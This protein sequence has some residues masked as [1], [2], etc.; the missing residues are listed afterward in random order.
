MPRRGWTDRPPNIERAT[1]GGLLAPDM[2]N[3]W[4]VNELDLVVETVEGARAAVSHQC[5]HG[6][7]QAGLRILSAVLVDV[8]HGDVDHDVIE[9][10]PVEVPVVRH[11]F[12]SWLLLY[13]PAVETNGGELNGVHVKCRELWVRA[14]RAIHDH[15]HGSLL[16]QVDGAWDEIDHDVDG[17]DPRQE[18]AESHRRTVRGQV[19]RRKQSPA[20]AIEHRDARGNLGEW[21]NWRSGRP[22]HHVR[23]RTVRG[24]GHAVRTGSN[25]RCGNHRTLRRAYL[26]RIY[27]SHS[28]GPRVRHKDPLPVGRR[29][30]AEGA[31]SHA[32]ACDERR[33]R[34]GAVD[35]SIS[36]DPRNTEDQQLVTSVIRRKEGPIWGDR[37]ASKR[38]PHGE[39]VGDQKL[40]GP[41]ADLRRVD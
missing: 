30:H 14:I 11:P 24:Y 10:I 12:A 40:L 33:G 22:A 20:Q 25:D 15:R 27:H 3:R 35:T 28:V 32:H 21:R 2:K 39:K 29:S 19:D 17:L 37:H 34:R 36:G 26:C 9:P 13:P 5:R 1:I 7:A 23:L 31:T 41:D 8:V 18:V 4:S 16:L 6:I 38:T